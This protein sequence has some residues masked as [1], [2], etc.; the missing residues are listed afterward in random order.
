MRLNRKSQIG[1]TLLAIVISLLGGTMAY[2]V[3][4][5]TAHNVIST[6]GVKITLFELSDPTGSGTDSLVPFED[7]E[8]IVPGKSY[9]KIPIVQNID[10]EPVWVRT[11]LTLTKTSPE[12][13]VTPIPDIESIMELEDVGS[14]WVYS[15]EHYYYN[16]P[17]TA[18]ELTQPLFRSIKFKDDI[19]VFDAPAGTVYS[20]TIVATATQTANNGTNPFTAGGWNG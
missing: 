16:N 18:E 14:N 7:I 2:F 1:L 5:N 3:T 9:S 19:A 13:T 10:T 11:Q 12:G 15:D 20:L 4:T 8:N 17:L 6:G